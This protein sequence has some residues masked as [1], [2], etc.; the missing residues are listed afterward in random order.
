MKKIE[1]QLKKINKN[2][3]LMKKIK[4]LLSENK[5]Y[6]KIGRTLNKPKNLIS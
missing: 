5:S 3:K 6:A 1:Q 2:K 4:E